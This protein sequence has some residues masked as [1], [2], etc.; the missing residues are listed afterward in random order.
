MAVLGGTVKVNGA[1]FRRTEELRKRFYI[2]LRLGIVRMQICRK[3]L[4][5][6]L[7]FLHT[8]EHVAVVIT[9]HVNIQSSYS[10]NTADQLQTDAIVH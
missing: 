9:K 3:F 7:Y 5:R 1:N 4:S 6:R 10:R 8:K 2:F